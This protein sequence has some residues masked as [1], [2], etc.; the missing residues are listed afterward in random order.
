VYD[1]GT[2]EHWKSQIAIAAKE[3]LPAF[4]IS[5]PVGVSLDFRMPY[6]GKHYRKLKAG[7]VLIDHPPFWHSVKPDS[8][9]LG[10]AV[11]DALTL[12]GF[13][14]DD[15]QVC[16]LNIQ[17]HYTSGQPGVGITIEEDPMPF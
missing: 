13:W 5:G 17:K 1:P 10:K 9:N 3:H 11:L 6:V 7:D 4:N 15:S 8:D 2:A 16:Q 14:H 12:I